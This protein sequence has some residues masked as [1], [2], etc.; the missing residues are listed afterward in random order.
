MKYD[1]LIKCFIAFCVGAI[2]YKF[3]SDRCFCGIVEGQE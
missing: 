2:I 3:I 1:L